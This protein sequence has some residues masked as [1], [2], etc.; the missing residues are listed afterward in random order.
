ME[1]VSAAEKRGVLQ[2]QW[3]IPVGS[4]SP[5]LGGGGQ[6]AW[7]RTRS[8]AWL[9]PLS[10]GTKCLSVAVEIYSLS[11]GPCSGVERGMNVRTLT[12]NCTY[13]PHTHPHLT[14]LRLKE[15]N[16]LLKIFNVLPPPVS[17]IL[18]RHPVHH[19][20]MSQNKCTHESHSNLAS[21]ARQ[22]LGPSVP[23]SSLSSQL[24]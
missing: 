11:G 6:G 21:V 16:F 17:C 23:T 1:S 13:T 7:A 10:P 19:F 8:V 4:P 22:H 3:A 5:R 9:A 12:H 20:P 24:H 2:T 18:C 15:G 14:Y